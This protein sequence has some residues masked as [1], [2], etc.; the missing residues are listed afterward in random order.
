MRSPQILLVSM[1]AEVSMPM[2]IRV[3]QDKV[4]PLLRR[5]LRRWQMDCKKTEQEES[6]TH[7]IEN[8]ATRPTSHQ[9]SSPLTHLLSHFLAES[10]K[11]SLCEIERPTFEMRCHPGPTDASFGKWQTDELL[12]LDL[13]LRRP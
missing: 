1:N 9:F 6:E 12:S 8:A 3:D 2:I 4:G 13:S 11:G 10:D 5:Q 7:D